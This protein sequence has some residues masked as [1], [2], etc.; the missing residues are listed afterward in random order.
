MNPSANIYYTLPQERVSNPQV[1]IAAQVPVGDSLKVNVPKPSISQIPEVPKRFQTPKAPIV[2][3]KIEFIP[4]AKDSI[5]FN[6]KTKSQQNQGFLNHTV[7]DDFLEPISQS[8]KMWV[9]GSVNSKIQYHSGASLEEKAEEKQQDHEGAK[10]KESDTIRVIPVSDSTYITSSDSIKAQNDSIDV[11]QKELIVQEKVNIEEKDSSRDVLTGLL[12]LAVAVTGVIR[13]TNFKY[14][15][16]LFSSVVFSQYARKMQKEENM[17]NQKAGFALSILFLFNTSLFIYEYIHYNNIKTFVDD[18]LILIPIAMGL[19]MAFGVV[20]G[21][22]YRF[23]S[24]VFESTQETNDYIF[25]TKLHDK[26]FGLIILPVILVVPYI[27]P[28][29]L[30]LLFNVGIGIFILLYIIQLF[31]GLLIILRD[32][33]SLF[34]MFLYLCA[35]E[36]LPLV[37]MYNILIN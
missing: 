27:D 7:V 16:D 18:S 3:K 17:R 9:K 31:R 22:L 25:Y 24:F 15:Q 8:D 33:A 32:V 36:I 26:I 34:Y 29:A 10:R 1:N 2:V 13:L 37:I 12:I 5:E 28:E 30:P 23:V 14:L 21:L 19:V 20:K 4:S 11:V 35:L 6:L